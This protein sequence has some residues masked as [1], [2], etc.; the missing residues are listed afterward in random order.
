LY[1]TVQSSEPLPPVALK[2]AVP[3]TPIVNGAEIVALGEQLAQRS[4]AGNVRFSQLDRSTR[5]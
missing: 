4:A 3:P 1:L 2:F 5:A